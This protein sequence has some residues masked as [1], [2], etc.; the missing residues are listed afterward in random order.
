MSKIRGINVY[1]CDKCNVPILVESDKED[2]KCTLCKEELKYIGS[3]ARP[4]YPDERL[5]L[6]ASIGEP[7]KYIKDSVWNVKGNKYI[8]NGEP[9]KLQV[10]D[11]VSN[12]PDEVRALIEKYAQ[13]NTDKYF[14][15]HMDKFIE[16]N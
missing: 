6:E 15:E 8:V 14:N 10:K 4:V 7:L 5:M 16:A 13:Y 1:Y 9:L 12:N 11:I 2:D 3:D